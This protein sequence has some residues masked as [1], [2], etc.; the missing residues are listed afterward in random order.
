MLFRSLTDTDVEVFV[1]SGAGINPTASV[2]WALSFSRNG[3]PYADAPEIK[4]IIE[5]KKAR[6]PKI[7]WP[8]SKTSE[9]LKKYPLRES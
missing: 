3:D 5:D 2:A 4:Q 6:L 8:T 1:K 7:P 9:R